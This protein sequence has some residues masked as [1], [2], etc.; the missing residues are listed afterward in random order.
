MRRQLTPEERQEKLNKLI[1]LINGGVMTPDEYRKEI[2][3]EFNLPD[4]ELG[5]MLY[6][7]S[8]EKDKLFKAIR[9]NIR[10]GTLV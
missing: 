10:N 3:N 6:S 2:L 9:D 4:M 5:G 7:E 1:A 8:R